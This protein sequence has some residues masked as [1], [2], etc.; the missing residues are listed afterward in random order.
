MHRLS[1]TVTAVLCLFLLALNSDRQAA[2]G[3][4]GALGHGGLGPSGASPDQ[5]SDWGRFELSGSDIQAVDAVDASTAWAVGTDGLLARWDGGGW[6]ADDNSKI[7]ALNFTGVDALAADA[8]WAVASRTAVARWDGMDWSVEQAFTGMADMNDISMVSPTDGWIV[9]GTSTNVP[10]VS[11]YNGSNWQ[12]WSN[13]GISRPLFGVDT[14][15]SNNA[16]AVGGRF[17]PMYAGEIVR[18]NGTGWTQ[19]QT[20]GSILLAVDMLDTAYGWAVGTSS[21]LWQWNGTTWTPAPAPLPAATIY[22]VVVNSRTD[23]WA[24]GYSFNTNTL[25]WHWDGT[26]WTS[27]TVPQ[28]VGLLGVKMLPGGQGWAAGPQST[29]YRWDG[30]AW[31][32]YSSRW[33]TGGYAAVD[34]VS[35]SDGW[36]VGANDPAIPIYGLQ[37]WNGT[38]WE[39]FHPPVNQHLM[40]DVDMVS[41]NAVWALGADGLIFRW[42][43]SAWT[44]EPGPGFAVY[45]LSMLTAADG[46]AVGNNGGIAHYDGTGWTSF[47]SPA[48][49]SLWAID[50]VD[51][52]EGW[53]GGIGFLLHFQNGTWTQVD[54]GT[55]NIIEGIHMLSASEGWAVGGGG[56]ILHYQGGTWTPQFG[57]PPD[58]LLQGV[59]MVSPTEGWAVGSNASI[60]GPAVLVHYQNGTWSSVLQPTGLPL[61]DVFAFDQNEAWVVGDAP[62]ILLRLGAVQA[63]TPTPVATA[64]R[65]ATPTVV[66]HTPTRTAMPTSS[67]S[68][69]ISAT[70][71][72]AITATPTTSISATPTACAVSFSDVPPTNTFYLFV[73]CLACRG[74]LGGYPDNTF[75][76]NNNVTRGQLSKVVSN[77]AGFSEPQPAQLFEDVSV[78]STFQ[79][80]IGRLASRGYISGYPCGGEG[81]PCGSGELP[82]FR[83]NNPAT[84]GQISK[85]VSNAAGFNDPPGLQLFE[86]VAPGSTFYDYVQR[87]ASRAIV[88]GYPCG[89]VGE[90]CGSDNLPYFRPGNSATRGQMSK[91]AASAFFPGCQTPAR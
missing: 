19:V 63:Q 7:G 46:W 41:S 35:P 90:P 13:S 10:I 32:V 65:T 29:I 25:V 59:H 51:A 14:V 18:W 21:A 89:G 61:R 82:Y 55:G 77:A 12:M 3:A 87:L 20:L 62:G 1:L 23:A 69:A 39:G 85:I 57:P 34:F 48:T 58:A 80:Y 28:T 16:W 2:S 68:P 9:G 24:V 60:F 54:P 5:G 52:T 66:P 37:H 76:P 8:A 33:T 83:P 88:N 49:S 79:A 86:D 56:T 71:T 36:A 78:G 74:I 91:I 64:T 45:A 6:I 40:T 38:T 84:R 75:K 27:L 11:R 43:G 81:E 73:R 22:D 67:P 4:E 30:A 50:M 70:E 44:Q 53:A 15:D 31:T 26:S 47:P 17:G 42:D 72:A